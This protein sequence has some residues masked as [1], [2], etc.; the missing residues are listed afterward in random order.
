MLQVRGDADFGEEPLDAEHGAQVGVEDLERDGSVVL[1]VAREIDRGHAATAD[2]S[3]DRVSAGEGCGES[4]RVGHE[5]PAS[6]GQSAL[7]SP[8]CAARDHRRKR[9]QLA[10]V[11]FG[12][13]VKFAI[14]RRTIVRPICSSAASTRADAR[15]R[16][17][18]T[19][20]SG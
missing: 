12:Q 2:L 1:D 11:Y 15:A 3:V 5:D 20:S 17:S 10:Q 4:S 9:I 7:T 16:H 6:R 13:I 8:T 14:A 18:R 19:C